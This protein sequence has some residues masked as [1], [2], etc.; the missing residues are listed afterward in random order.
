MP[1][2]SVMLAP[3]GTSSPAMTGAPRSTVELP[4][5]NRAQPVM[6]SNSGPPANATMMPADADVMS[7]LTL[8]MLPEGQVTSV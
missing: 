4:A 5:E 6:F 3:G 8:D 7:I 1:R 2:T